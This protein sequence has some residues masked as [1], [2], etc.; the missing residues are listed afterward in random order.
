[1]TPTTSA[2][3]DAARETQ[4][5]AKVVLDR[6]GDASLI[7]GVVTKIGDRVFDGSLRSRLETMRDSLLPQA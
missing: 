7:A 3:E 4:R 5:V 6:K 2:F 1:M